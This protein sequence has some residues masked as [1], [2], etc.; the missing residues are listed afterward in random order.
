MIKYKKL[1]KQLEKHKHELKQFNKYIDHTIINCAQLKLDKLIDFFQGEGYAIYSD[2]SNNDNKY[3]LIYL[4]NDNN[5]TKWN[6]L[7]V[8]I[9]KYSD[10]NTLNSRPGKIYNEYQ[11]RLVKVIIPGVRLNWYTNFYILFLHYVLS[12]TF[13][14]FC[15]F[16]IIMLFIFCIYINTFKSHNKLIIF[17]LHY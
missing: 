3:T 2:V 5:A 1:Q 8:Y 17:I 14:T 4:I 9:E 11:Y 6:Q 13:I 15:F 7:A 16:N 12:C 10:E